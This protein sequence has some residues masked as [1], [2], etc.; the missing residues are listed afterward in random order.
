MV[1]SFGI[2]VVGHRTPLARAHPVHPW[3]RF[4]RSITQFVA[5]AVSCRTLVET[6]LEE[7]YSFRPG[8]QGPA[9][10][11]WDMNSLRQVQ[12]HG[13]SSSSSR[14]PTPSRPHSQ[15][16]ATSAAKQ[17]ASPCFAMPP[18]DFGKRFLFLRE[19][20]RWRTALVSSRSSRFRRSREVRLRAV[21]FSRSSE[22]SCP[23]ALAIP[24]LRGPADRPTLC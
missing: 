12:P 23:E 14:R 9:D 13:S 17:S 18:G 20:S 7:T 21:H 6:S 22:L 11:E 2:S 15:V 5:D 8:W 19:S 10:L 4:D 1:P 16:G 3:V 24:R